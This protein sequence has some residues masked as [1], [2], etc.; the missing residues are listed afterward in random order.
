VR[1]RLQK[2]LPEVM[3]DPEITGKLIASGLQPAYE[4]AA[5]VAAQIDGELPRMRATA[6]RAKIQAE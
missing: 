5:A 2:A 1:A 3:A 4:S 6:A